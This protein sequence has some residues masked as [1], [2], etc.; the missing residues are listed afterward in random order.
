MTD[1]RWHEWARQRK[2]K[3]GEGWKKIH[4]MTNGDHGRHDH[5]GEEGESGRD[6]GENDH[7]EGGSG[8]DEGGSGRGGE[9]CG[10]RHDE[11]ESVSGGEGCGTGCGYDDGR[12][13]PSGLQGVRREMEG[14][15]LEL[16]VIEG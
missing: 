10:D 7:G 6:E 9:G 12:D 16:S 8:R 14:Q 11:E 2:W 15:V 4:F 13:H 3:G 5:R 1:V